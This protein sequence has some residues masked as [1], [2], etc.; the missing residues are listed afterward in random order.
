MGRLFDKYGPKWLVLIGMIIVTIDLF[1]YTRITPDVS[2]G[3]LVAMHIFLMIGLAMILMPAQTNGLNQ[4]PSHYYPHGTA[5]LNT[6][7]QV[8]GAIGTAIAVSLLSSGQHKYLS[9]A[10]DPQSQE[11]LVN[12]FTNGAQSAFTFSLIMALIG[13]VS[14]LFIKKV[15]VIDSTSSK[16]RILH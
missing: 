6:L 13:L 1:M 3:Q 16:N 9:Q 7:Q 15:K 12:A 2:L 11:T 5:I 8:S 14:A 4:L 10:S